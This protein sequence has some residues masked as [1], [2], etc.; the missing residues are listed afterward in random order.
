MANKALKILKTLQKK[1]PIMVIDKFCEFCQNES[2]PNPIVVT[3]ISMV[4]DSSRKIASIL[5]NKKKVDLAYIFVNGDNLAKAINC[6]T[7][8]VSA[9]LD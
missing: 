5:I 9:N 1:N 6:E 3:K 4:K 8:A 2:R 7:Y